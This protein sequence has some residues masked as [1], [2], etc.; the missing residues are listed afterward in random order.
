MQ[1]YNSK[2]KNI[3][4][5][6]VDWGT[7]RIGLA[8]ADSETNLAIPYKTVKNIK[9]V[10]EVI[11]EEEVEKIIIGSPLTLRNEEGK[12]RKRVDEFISELKKKTGLPIETVDERLTTRLAKS[13]SG[14]RKV[15]AEKDAVSAMLI[16][17]TYLDSK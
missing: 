8:M 5:L 4:Y 9:E 2:F 16:L 12:N 7:D 6:G 3:K 13:L 15:K 11:K 14:D 17:Q 10:V 1:N